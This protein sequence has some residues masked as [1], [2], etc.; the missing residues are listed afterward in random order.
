MNYCKYTDLHISQYS[1]FPSFL[2]KMKINHSPDSNLCAEIIST[3]S[4][5]YRKQEQGTYIISNK[6][7]K[8]AAGEVTTE[9]THTRKPMA[10]IIRVIWHNIVSLKSTKY[11]KKHA[12]LL[13][14]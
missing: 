3:G 2:F 4:L 11:L 12:Q 10:F 9:L 8:M 5:L 13:L 1:T 14:F 7:P 6:I